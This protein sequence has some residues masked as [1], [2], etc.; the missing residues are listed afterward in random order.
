[1][2]G[3]ALDRV[4]E[5]TALEDDGT[6]AARERAGRTAL[7]SPEL[8]A[9]L[10]W[11]A[12]STHARSAVEVGSAGGVSGLWLLRG[13]A[14]RGVLTTIDDDPHAH[15]LAT[16]AFDRAG[17]GGRVRA[18]L[19]D[20]GE[21]LPRL[22]D[23]SYDLVILQGSAFG[24]VDPLEHGRRLLRTGGV[25]VA[26]GLLASGDHADAR[27]RFVQALADDPTFSAVVLPIDEGVALATRLEDPEDDDAGDDDAG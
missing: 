9:L 6:T 4:R 5:L 18:I 22:S 25:L 12:V 15:G 21:V 16:E 7:P 11:V 23:G 14:E 10:R 26:L 13:L 3:A 2:D 20:P 1:M 27:A 17:A 8:G 24:T 19:G